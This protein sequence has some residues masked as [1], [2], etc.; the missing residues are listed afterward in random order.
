MAL[1]A[2][3]GTSVIFKR[4]QDNIKRQDWFSVGLEILAVVFGVFLALQ[5]DNWNEWRHERS[6]E[7]DYLV[8]LYADINSSIDT[9]RAAIDYMTLHADR[10][11]VVLRSLKA[12][13]IDQDDQLDFAN[14]LFQLGNVVPPYLA[15][16][17]INE[18]RATGKGSVF[19]AAN[20]KQELN[21]LLA[22]RRYYMSFFNIVADRLAPHVVY[23]HSQVSFQIDRSNAGSQEIRWEDLQVDLSLLCD[24]ARFFNAVSAGRTSSYD[25][26]FWSNLELE[27]LEHFLETLQV[28]M[29]R[30]G[31]SPQDP[32]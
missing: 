8:R 21:Q 25:T 29:D 18:L 32:G 9:A 22:Q 4:F 7:R 30:Q 27:R 1:R 19:R 16:G 28:E 24:D 2:D 14:G 12:C 11:N 23:V 17:T 5:A 26:V 13:R 15:D 10:A 31:L 6:E 20:I 3:T